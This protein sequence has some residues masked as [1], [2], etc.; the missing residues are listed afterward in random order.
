MHGAG[1]LAVAERH[2]QRSRLRA[3][4][5][6]ER[7]EGLGL[8]PGALAA[9][10][11]A[12][13]F[14]LGGGMYA[15]RKRAAGRVVPPTGRTVTIGLLSEEREAEVDKVKK[16]N[17][18]TE[19]TDKKEA[20]LRRL[21]G[22]LEKTLRDQSVQLEVNI[23]CTVKSR[24]PEQ[25]RMIYDTYDAVAQ[26]VGVAA[27]DAPLKRTTIRV[28][29]GWKREYTN[30]FRAA[31]RVITYWRGFTEADPPPG[32]EHV[33]AKV[34]LHKADSEFL[35][36]SRVGPEIC[37][38]VSDVAS[39]SV[40]ASG[41]GSGSAGSGATQ[42]LA[43]PLVGIMIDASA[44]ILTVPHGRRG[45]VESWLRAERPNELNENNSGFLELA[46]IPQRPAWPDFASNL[47][48]LFS[49]VSGAATT[50]ANARV[51]RVVRHAKLKTK[52]AY[53]MNP[54][55]C[56]VMLFFVFAGP[57]PT[58]ETPDDVA[59]AHHVAS[60]K[61]GFDAM[62]REGV[63]VAAIDLKMRDVHFNSRGRGAMNTTSIV[64]TALGGIV[65]GSVPAT[66]RGRTY[67][68]YIP[69]VAVEGESNWKQGFGRPEAELYTP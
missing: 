50:D 29:K 62:I 6:R 52:L 11:V 32:V 30:A 39:A 12:L 55:T 19:K 24:F 58:E 23:Y 14:A 36:F 21:Y 66:G 18:I 17:A 45:F 13:S 40:S 53:G 63:S 5:W 38:F 59:Q 7:G 48:G 65:P 28:P 20:Y 8:R 51:V 27:G 54:A 2:D 43:A 26:N 67:A 31:E 60:V 22:S 1:V 16:P 37:K 25:A 61:A 68:D 9:S 10:A 47:L 3:Q 35:H 49:T 57:A 69:T 56:T 15:W 46:G 33:Y 64:K 34:T 4:T 41:S 44:G 42:N